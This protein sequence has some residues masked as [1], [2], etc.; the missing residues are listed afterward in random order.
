[1]CSG[2]GN[3]YHFNACHKNL[4]GWLP[5]ASVQ[6]I[7]TSG[8]YRVYSHD[9][10][11]LGSGLKYGLKIH[12]DTRDYWVEMRQKITGN[13]TL[14]NGVLLL[15]S[16]WAQ[17]N[18]GTDLLDTTP[19]TAGGAADAA[20][21]VGRTFEDTNAKVKIKPLALGGTTPRFMDVQVTFTFTNLVPT[22]RIA[23]T[24]DLQ[25]FA[26]TITSS[27]GAV[28]TIENSSDLKTWSTLATVTNTTGT[29]QYLDSRTPVQ[30]RR[31]YRV[32][33]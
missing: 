10:A 26:L 15:W 17:S 13:T 33:G 25:K 19:G 14:Q 3:A 21:L 20:L 28:L 2:Y 30:P 29:T 31:F 22:V 12:K 9:I 27:P 6:T 1:M 11:A 24:P 32:R 5:D 7:T 18:G 4:L 23:L 16:P 8:V